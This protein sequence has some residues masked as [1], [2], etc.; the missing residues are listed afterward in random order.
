M[1]ENL[2]SMIEIGRLI[3]NTRKEQGLTQEELAGLSGTGRRFI[4]DVERGKANVQMDKL[5]L[6]IC[7]LGLSVYICNR[8][9]KK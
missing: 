2:S 7:A 4:S 8:W 3:S 1:S 5:L 6:V 9:M